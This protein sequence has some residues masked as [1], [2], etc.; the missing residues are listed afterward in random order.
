MSRYAIGAFAT[1]ALLLAC[2]AAAE[3]QLR[4]CLMKAIPDLE[5]GISPADV[6]A[7]GVV[8]ECRE[9]WATDKTCNL[10]CQ[11]T[12]ANTLKTTILPDVLKFRAA[13]RRAGKSQ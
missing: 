2:P 8:E 6:I 3:S 11:A 7:A 13:K 5:D 12:V 9:T 4:A 10:N 1:V